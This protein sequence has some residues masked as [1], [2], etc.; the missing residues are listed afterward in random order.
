MGHH[1]SPKMLIFW[2]SWSKLQP[3]WTTTDKNL[4]C[5]SY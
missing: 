4:S 3:A 1:K 5:L 2:V